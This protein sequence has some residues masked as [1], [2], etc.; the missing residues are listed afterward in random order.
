MA[1]SILQTERCCYYCGRLDGLE[2]HHV[3]GG[4]NR[5]ISDRYGLWIWCDSYH[6]R[7]LKEGVQYNKYKNLQLKQDAQMA[8]EKTHPRSMW[9]ELIRKN[10][11]GTVEKGEID[12]AEYKKRID[13]AYAMLFDS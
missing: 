9:M 6:H 12:N 5:K 3:F 1:K 2:K 10:Y 7:D 4:P 8:F 11:L 13:E